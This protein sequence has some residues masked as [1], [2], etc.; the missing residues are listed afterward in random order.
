MDR[1]LY[2]RQVYKSPTANRQ[3][4]YAELLMKQGTETNPVGSPL[5]A[6]ARVGTAGIG[7]YLANQAEETEKQYNTERQALL[8]KALSGDPTQAANI[9]LSLSLIHI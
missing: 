1:A 4:R 3:S 6:I 7:G 2:G 9:L 5:E 8:A